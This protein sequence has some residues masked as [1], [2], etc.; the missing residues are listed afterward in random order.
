MNTKIISV[1][2]FGIP[3]KMN[4][5]DYDYYK[6]NN[7]HN[8]GL[9]IISKCIESDDNCWEPYQTE[10][11]KELLKGGSN[12]FIDVG[13]HLGYYS[14]LASSLNNSVCSIDGNKIYSDLFK[15]TIQ[16]NNIINI[17]QCDEFINKHTDIKN[18]LHMYNYIKLIKCDIEGYE[19]EFIDLI[20]SRLQ[21]K[22]IENLILEISPSL[23]TNYPEYVLKIKSL[24]YN[25]YDIGLSHQRKLDSKTQLSSLRD[26][27]LFIDNLY[28]MTNYI[29]NFSEKQSNFL[30][31]FNYY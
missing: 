11:T 18:L 27:L 26:K 6:K 4:I 23:R 5:F 8:E 1:D 7:I 13:S 12:V 10:I 20:L 15:N 30:F 3:K 31:T 21:D 17:N 19:I 22:S 24:G 14:L 9:D 29:N 25:I 16:L 2:F 28:E